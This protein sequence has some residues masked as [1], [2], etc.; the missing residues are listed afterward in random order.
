[1]APQ[2][3]PT[4]PN[5]SRRLQFWALGPRPLEDVFLKNAWLFLGLST[6]SALAV[7]LGGCDETIEATPIPATSASTT[8]DASTTT[9]ADAAAACKPGDLSGFAPTWKEPIGLAQAK[10]SPTQIATLTTCV[11]ADPKRNEAACT[12]FF[13]DGANAACLECGYTQTTKPKLGALVSNGASVQVNYP[14]CVALTTADV[15]PTGCG[16]KVQASELCLDFACVSACPVPTGND[17]AFQALLKCQEE[18][19]KTVCKTYVDA[20][21]C[22]DPFLAAGGKSAVCAPVVQNFGERVS[23]YLSLFC[24]SGSAD[25]GTDA[26][27]DA[28]SGG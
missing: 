22:V 19:A 23:Q 9:P 14:G 28:P 15:T 20:A 25:A 3:A 13:A 5:A 2:F 7:G 17:A 6:L 11:W 21:K 10:C 27:S 26:P 12:A 8:S 1:M 24:G 18:A 16:A 4:L